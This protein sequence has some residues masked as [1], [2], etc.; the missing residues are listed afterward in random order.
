[1]K[2]LITKLLKGRV[3]TVLMGPLRGTKLRYTSLIKG[4]VYLKSYEPDKQRAFD[5]F[6]K[7]GS[8]FFDIGANVGLHSYYVTRKHPDVRVFSFEPLPSNA[9][10][11]RET[12]KIN[13]FSNIEVIEKAMSSRNGEAFFNM[14]D[15]NS[16]GMLSQATTELTVKTISLDNY[17]IENKNYPDLI[18]IDVEGA[19]SIVLEGARK[20][21]QERPPIFIIELHSPEQDLKVSGLLT[22]SN[23]T[24]FRLNTNLKK[25]ASQF[26]IKVKNVNASWP[27]P[28]GVWGSIVAI[29][30]DQLKSNNPQV[31]KG[32]EDV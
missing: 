5:L 7:P 3:W 32:N 19:E 14:S 8:T 10:Y 27:D 22:A 9:E 1:M 13:Q 21:M 26:L 30:S 17:V 25:N 16:K 15:N 20:L 23:Y 12:L 28:Q 18:K 24:I 29:N 6:L 11:I 31:E 4:R 2:R